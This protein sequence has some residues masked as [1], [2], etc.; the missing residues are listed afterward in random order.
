MKDSSLESPA[1]PPQCFSVSKAYDASPSPS[2]VDTS[3]RF[4]QIP[5]MAD[6]NRADRLQSLLRLSRE[7]GREDRGLAILAEGN[8]STRL[9]DGRFFVKASGANLGTLSE[10]GVVECVAT[11]L[12]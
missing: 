12:V 5:A 3:A 9:E 6:R 8:T 7:L 4:R 1:A 2:V 10:L 11:G